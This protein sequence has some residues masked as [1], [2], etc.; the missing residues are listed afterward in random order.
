MRT[1]I[2]WVILGIPMTQPSLYWGLWPRMA[3]RKF[4]SCWPAYKHGVFER[5][6]LFWSWPSRGCNILTHLKICG[7]SKEGIESSYFS[8]ITRLRCKEW[9]PGCWRKDSATLQNF[10]HLNLGTKKN[11][12]ISMGT[13]LKWRQLVYRSATQTN[14]CYST[15]S[16]WLTKILERFAYSLVFQN[17][18]LYTPEI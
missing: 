11:D 5:E 12:K 1:C 15:S 17:R 18:F 14:M 9:L 7:I 13:A 8:I 3:R 6:R 10:C 2:L 16:I 4:G